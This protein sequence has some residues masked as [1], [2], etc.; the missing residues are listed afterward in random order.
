M[1]GVLMATRAVLRRRG[2]TV[3]LEQLLDPPPLP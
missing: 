1:P 3:G 2:L